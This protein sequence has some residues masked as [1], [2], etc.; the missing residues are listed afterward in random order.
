M[1]VGTKERLLIFRLAF[2]FGSRLVML[3]FD[4]RDLIF[5]LEL[6]ENMSR[7]RNGGDRRSLEE[8]RN[9][10]DVFRK[11]TV[12]ADDWLFNVS[13][14]FARLHAACDTTFIYWE[15]N[16]FRLYLQDLFLTVRDPHR[17]HVRSDSSRFDISVPSFSSS[18]PLFAI[19]SRLS[20]P[21]VTTNQRDWS[22]PTRAK[23]WRCSIRLTWFEGDERGRE[24][25]DHLAFSLV[26]PPRIIQDDRRRSP[27][28][29]S[30]A[31]GSRWS[32][33]LQ[34]E[35]QRR[36]TASRSETDSMLRWIHQY[37][38]FGL[39]AER[40]V[41]DLLLGA[42]ESYLDKIFYDYTTAS[43]TDWNTYSEMRNLASQKYGLDLHEPHLPSKTLE[44]VLRS[45]CSPCPHLRLSFQGCDV[46]DI[47]RNLNGFVS[48]HYYN[49]NTQM[50][51][52]RSSNNKF[53]RTTNIRHV[54]NSIRTHGIGI[55]NTA[56]RSLSLSL[57][58]GYSMSENLNL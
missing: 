23:S 53:L 7:G 9:L 13:L 39:F 16:S 22:K 8:T 54:A 57:F 45:P 20:E 35:F 15:R 41:Q 58:S 21:F 44:Q 46:L 5:P 26:F 29:V 37:Q 11:V 12:I 55:M 31:F 33:C 42:V 6:T 47:L 51:I 24:R 32:Q 28:F 50:F 38:R 14:T 27:L 1:S 52:E 25:S 56:V 19:V 30:R 4:W 40:C 48:Q 49:I 43:S 3:A 10:S 34:S 17:L 36:H 2:S 18:S